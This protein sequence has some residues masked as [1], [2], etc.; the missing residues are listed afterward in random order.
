[1][2]AVTI[3]IG[4]INQCN[5]R[6]FHTPRLENNYEAHLPAVEDATTTSSWLPRAHAHP[7]WPRGHQCPASERASP[8]QRVSVARATFPRSVRLRGA[9]Q[10]T[11][12]FQRRFRSDNFLLLVRSGGSKEGSARLGIVIGRRQAARAVDRA[13]L[14][15]GIREVF[16]GRRNDLGQIDVVIR[17]RGP[18]AARVDS[19]MRAELMDLLERTAS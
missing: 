19:A 12:A 11:G 13:R 4:A 3:D 5:T 7:G 2:D 14:R 1:M 8:P 9:A 10:F 18:S 17:F 16:R 15:R 6:L